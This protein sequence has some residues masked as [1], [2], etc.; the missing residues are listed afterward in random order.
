MSDIVFVAHHRVPPWCSRYSWV[1]AFGG[2]MFLM[3]WVFSSSVVANM[4]DLPFGCGYGR[5]VGA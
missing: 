2:Q 1:G 5:N 3:R 4:V